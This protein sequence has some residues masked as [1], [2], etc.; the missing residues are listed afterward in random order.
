MGRKRT[1][2]YGRCWWSKKRD[3]RATLCLAARTDDQ[4]AD[5]D[6][7]AA[8]LSEMAY[9]ARRRREVVHGDLVAM[10]ELAESARLWAL[11]EH[12]EAWHIDLF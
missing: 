8:V 1:V 5:Y 9:A 10:L 7:R 11:L 2:V 12:E 6:G 3:G 4:V